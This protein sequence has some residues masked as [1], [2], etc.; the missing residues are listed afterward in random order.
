MIRMGW[1]VIVAS[2]PEKQSNPRGIRRSTLNDEPD[3]VESDARARLCAIKSLEHGQITKP[4]TRLAEPHC[5]I[6]GGDPDRLDAPGRGPGLGRGRMGI[7]YDD[8][9][10]GDCGPDGQVDASRGGPSR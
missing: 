2:W 10:R 4:P 6:R 1:L 8:P 5:A 7:K 9:R 3:S